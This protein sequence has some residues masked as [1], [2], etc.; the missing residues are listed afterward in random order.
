MSAPRYRDARVGGCLS[1]R[2]EH[3]ENGEILLGADEPLA[4]HADRLNDRLAYWAERA[5]E[6]TFVA[7]RD[8]TVPGGGDWVRIGYGEMLERAR[9]IGQALL[10]RGLSTERPLA[11]LSDND[12]EH[13][14]LA[15]GAMWAGVPWVPISP[16]VVRLPP[17]HPIA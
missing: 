5:P 4:A 12:L 16:C 13:L 10:D 17:I 14:S 3:R 11:I 8:P 9:A 2:V 15:M 1:A 6:R 7:R